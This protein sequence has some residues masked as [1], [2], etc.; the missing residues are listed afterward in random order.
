M[1]RIITTCHKAG[2]DQYGHRLLAG[3]HHFP[4]GSGV[5]WYT[6]GYDLPPGPVPVTQ[7][8]INGIERLTRFLGKHPQY[9]PPGWQWDVRRFA[10]KVF[11]VVDDILSGEPG[12][13][14]WVDA[15]IVPYQD[16]PEGY[17]EELLGE[18]FMAVLNR[19]GMHTETGFWLMNT[20]HKHAREFCEDWLDAYESERFL[21]LSEWHDCAI[22]D[23]LLKRATTQNLVTVVG[24]SGDYDVDMHPMSRIELGKYLDHCKGPVRKHLGH[25]PENSHRALSQAA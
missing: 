19:R 10:R 1:R 6:E 23:S 8:D 11:A 3:L 12:V 20:A 17:L 18:H 21:K 25:S 24:L 9:V 16:I 7:R 2:F 15:D 13:V 22:L 5:I 14:A 4:A